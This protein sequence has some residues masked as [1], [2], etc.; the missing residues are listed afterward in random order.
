MAA[1]AAPKSVIFV[2]RPAAFSIP[3]GRSRW[4]WQISLA[5]LLGVGQNGGIIALIRSMQNQDGDHLKAGSIGLTGMLDGR[6]GKAPNFGSVVARVRGN[7]DLPGF[8]SIGASTSKRSRR[9]ATSG[10]TRTS[11]SLTSCRTGTPRSSTGRTARC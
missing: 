11:P 10:G 8:M 3:R 2:C 5:Q 4:V 6:E 1:T 7:R 9:T